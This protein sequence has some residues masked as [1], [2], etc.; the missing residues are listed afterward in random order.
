MV[1]WDFGFVLGAFNRP[2]LPDWDD[3]IVW[4]VGLVSRRSGLFHA[5]AVLF[6]FVA[7]AVLELLVKD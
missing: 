6:P 7:G 2:G 3:G 4:V 5:V 1:V